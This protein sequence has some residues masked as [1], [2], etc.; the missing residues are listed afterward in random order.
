MVAGMEEV[1]VRPAALERVVADARQAAVGE[2]PLPRQRPV[3]ARRLIKLAHQAELNDARED[4]SALGLLWFGLLLAG[5]ILGP[6]W[7]MRG[8]RWLGGAVCLAVALAVMVFH[9]RGE[10]IHRTRE[11]RLARSLGELPFPVDGLI[12]HLTA[13]RPLADLH[14]RAAVAPELLADAVRTLDAGATIEWLSPRHARLALTPRQLRPARHKHPAILGGD[15]PLVH[16]LVDK[17]LV[18]LH[19]EVR[20][21]R[22]DLGGE[23]TSDR[24]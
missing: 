14:L 21:E 9:R 12:D 10:R 22:L 24:A 4:G 1:P 17:V 23:V 20:V 3:P 7:L 6:L 13:D 5:A 11:E 15:L 19:R 8:P 16:A 18:P 2:R